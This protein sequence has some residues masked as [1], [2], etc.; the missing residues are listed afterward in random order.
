VTATVRRATPDDADR[1]I[2]LVA[3]YCAADEH[4]FDRSVVEAG[5]APLLAGDDVGVVWL[6]DID[7]ELDGYIVVTWGWSIEIGGL[8]VVLDEIYVRARGRGHGS[9]LIEHA[10]A[11]CRRR[12]VKRIFLETERRNEPARRLYLRHGYT[13]DDSI[14]MS[15][16][17][18]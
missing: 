2:E 9:R 16:E 13:V 6:L 5:L 18:N 10:E 14:W 11:D 17:L 15:K 7:G 8:D 1:L 4:R 3:E 12:G